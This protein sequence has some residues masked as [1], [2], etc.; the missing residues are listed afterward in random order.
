MTEKSKASQA[1]RPPLTDDEI[2]N[3]SIDDLLR[4]K[5]S[6]EEKAR[7]RQFN[8][9]REQRIK[10]RSVRLNVEQSALL[11]D[12]REVGWNVENVWDI[13]TTRYRYPEA[14]PVLLKHL[15]LPYSDRTR[16]GIARALAVKEPEAI[17]AW[18][19]IVEEYRKAPSGWG[20]IGPGETQEFWLGTKSALAATLAVL[21]T[22]D[23]MPELVELAKDKSLGSSR[24]LLLSA[25]RK[26][27]SELAKQ[28]IDELRNDPDVETEIRS[29]KR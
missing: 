10:E 9:E 24:I 13:A 12:L 14:I 22:K 8:L 19:L 26:S 16:E 4:I 2:R 5:L 7:R 20:P 15:I 6:D 1:N 11:A 17:K 18:P 27:K 21:V 3:L 25:L 29:W 23:T 28:T